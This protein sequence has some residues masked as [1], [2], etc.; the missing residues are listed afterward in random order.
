MEINFVDYKSS[1]FTVK[2][3]NNMGKYK[4]DCYIMISTL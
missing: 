4:E 3:P 1:I 2:Y